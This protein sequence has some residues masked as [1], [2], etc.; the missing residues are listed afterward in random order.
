ME[1]QGVLQPVAFRH[2]V[3]DIVSGYRGDAQL[4]GQVD[5]PAVAGGVALHQVCCNS[6]NTLSAPNQSRY[7]RSWVSASA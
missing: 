5:E 7:C 1:T 3:V 6:T 2:V 4:A